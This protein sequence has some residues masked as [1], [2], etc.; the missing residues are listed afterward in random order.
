MH[1][2]CYN[3]IV[4]APTV[5]VRSNEPNPIRPVG[6]DVTLTC[7]VELSPIVGVS[8]TVN[9]QLTNPAGI[10]RSTTI[11]SVSGSTYTI[12][13]MV[14]SFG[15]GQS[16]FYTCRATV[17]A[18][19]SNSFIIPGVASAMTKVATSEYKIS[20]VVSSNNDYRDQWQR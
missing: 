10:P 7:V 15:R 19:L 14:R 9:I 3:I 4:P 8:V 5:N 1:L 6:S 11:P 20:I 2:Q 12:T 18:T 13:S 17:S 16:G